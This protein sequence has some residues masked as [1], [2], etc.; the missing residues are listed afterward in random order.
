TNGDT[1]KL[2]ANQKGYTL[3][4][5]LIVLA[6]IGLLVSIALPRIRD[7]QQR[8]KEAVLRENLF[9]IRETID[10]YKGDKG[11]YPSSLQQLV[12]DGYLRKMPYDPITG[13]SDSWLEVPEEMG[14]S[15]DPTAQ[16]G[17]WDVQSGASGTALDGTPYGE[18]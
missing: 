6:I 3:I 7:A 4:E 18:L 17:I 14:E 11:K 1:V 10:Q 5:L 2:S 13:R 9:R 16:P 15:S 12:D 8:A